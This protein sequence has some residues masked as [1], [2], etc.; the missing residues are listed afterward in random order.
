MR[1]ESWEQILGK[2]MHGNTLSVND[3]SQTTEGASCR[4][5][6]SSQLLTCMLLFASLDLN[7]RI[8]HMFASHGNLQY[9]L[10]PKMFLYLCSIIEELPDSQIKDN[11]L[12]SPYLLAVRGTVS[13]GFAPVHRPAE[14]PGVDSGAALHCGTPC[15]VRRGLQASPSV[16]P[17]PSEQLPR[18]MTGKTHCCLGSLLPGVHAGT[19]GVCFHSYLRATGH[20]IP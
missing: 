5:K 18:P 12:F 19:Q 11:S 9:T 8:P 14:A 16:D 1:Q 4:K 2:G 10:M 17:A 3:F 13:V 20:Q 7:P 6:I 15:P